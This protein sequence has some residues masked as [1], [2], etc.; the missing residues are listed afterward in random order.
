MKLILVL[1]IVGILAIGT[2]ATATV[3]SDIVLHDNTLPNSTVKINPYTQDGAYSWTVE[4]QNQ[5]ARNSYWYRIGGASVATPLSALTVDHISSS[6]TDATVYY[7]SANLDISVLY[8][9]VGGDSGSGSSDLYQTVTITNKTS[10]SMAF[11]L[12]EYVNYNICETPLGDTAT[13]ISSTNINQTQGG[14]TGMIGVNSIPSYW[15]M[16]DAT[17]LFNK[18]NTQSFTNLANAASPSTGDVAFAFQW[19]K[20]IATHGAMQVSQDMGITGA[21][22][23]PSSFVALI[24]ALGALLPALR[25]RRH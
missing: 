22:P 15:E 19:D 16:G 4:L 7:T 25:R 23:E 13:R 14:T 10:S 8:S 9:L 11:H 12:F 24:G 18:L 21:V 6:A 2:A 17:A 3:A 20:S 5:L 1:A